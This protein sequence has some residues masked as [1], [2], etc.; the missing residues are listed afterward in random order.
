[1]L[2]DGLPAWRAHAVTYYS[3]IP[4]ES[5]GQRVQLFVAEFDGTRPGHPPKPVLMLHGRSVPALPVFDL[6]GTSPTRDYSWA[7]YLMR[8]GFDVFVMDLLGSG[9][10]PRPM[11]DDPCNA[12]PSPPTPAQ[13]GDQKKLIPNPLDAECPVKYPYQLYN[14]DSEVAQVKTVVEYIINLRGV[15]SVALVSYSAGAFTLGPFTLRHPEYVKSLLL[16]APIFPPQGRSAAPPSPWPGWPMNVSTRSDLFEPWNKELHTDIQRDDAILDLAWAQIMSNDLVGLTWGGAIKDQPEGVIRWRNSLWWGWNTAAVGQPGILG[17]RVPVLIMYGHYDT[18]ITKPAAPP[19][20][21]FS[22]RALYD[23]IPG[24]RKISI[25]FD[26]A[27]HYLPWERIA[28]RL[29]HRV[30]SEWLEMAAVNSP[31]VSL[32]SDRW[33]V[34]W[35]GIFWPEDWPFI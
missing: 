1:M 3:T 19:A 23:A 4:P 17:D 12:A 10:S 5:P 18:Q 24:P 31:I 13:G 35:D 34:G 22:V 15:S 6:G 7:Q 28:P 25:K 29:L 27:G 32:T 33:S 11:M 9:L 14:T 16:C 8:A 26:D 2:M 21:A 30:S 20:P